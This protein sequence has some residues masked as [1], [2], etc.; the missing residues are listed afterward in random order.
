MIKQKIAVVALALLIGGCTLTYTMDIQQGNP[1]TQAQIEKLRPG[2]TRQEVRFVLGT[3]IIE[4]PF[5]GNRWD[6]F[7]SLH[8]GGAPTEIQQRISVFFDGDT[9]KSVKG[10]VQNEA[11]AHAAVE[12]D[13]EGSGLFNNSWNFITQSWEQIWK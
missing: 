11:T 3:P 10:K 1:V 12:T 4:D 5:H 9:L 2:M 7:F 6:Y 8:T 13:G